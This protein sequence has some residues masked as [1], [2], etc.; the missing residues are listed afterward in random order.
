MRTIFE[1]GVDVGRGLLRSALNEA[2]NLHAE[3]VDIPY[4]YKFYTGITRREQS[5]RKLIRAKIFDYIAILFFV[6]ISFSLIFR[7]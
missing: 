5:A 3:G 7:I 2:R 6:F 1:N 4:S